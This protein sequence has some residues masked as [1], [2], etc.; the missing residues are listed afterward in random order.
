MRANARKSSPGPSQCFVIFSAKSSPIPPVAR[1]CSH[2]CSFPSQLQYRVRAMRGLR[3]PAHRRVSVMSARA[4]FR[5]AAPVPLATSITS[6]IITCGH[7]PISHRAVRFSWPRRRSSSTTPG[8]PSRRRF[9]GQPS[10]RRRVSATKS[11]QQQKSTT[12][13]A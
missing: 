6:I 11:H 1:S 12:G 3:Y 7:L 4:S 10:S 8:R 5:P 13:R 9:V 2:R